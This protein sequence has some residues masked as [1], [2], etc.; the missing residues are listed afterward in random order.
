MRSELK[1]I[2]DALVRYQNTGI[3]NNV[4]VVG[5]RGC[6]KTLSMRYLQKLFADQGLT[7]LYS[8]CRLQNTSY[9]LLAEFLGVRARGVSFA[10]LAER[11][12]RKYTDK[13]VVV[14]DEVD[15]LSEKDRNKDLLYFL[16]RAPEN[17]MVVCLSNNPRW[18][19]V[20]D[21]S[22]QST[23]Q[24]EL[25]Y[26]R[27]YTPDELTAILRERA[28][29]G[30]GKTK[31]ESLANIAALAA[32]YADSDVRVALKTLYYSALE[33]DTPLDTIF[34]RARLDIVVEVV[35]NLN[36]KNLMILKAA[37]PGDRQVKDV[38]ESYRRLCREH[39]DE[40]FSY[41]Y[42]YS[43]L[44]YLQSLGLILLISTKVRRTYTK[45]I[46][47]TFP[48]DVLNTVWQYRFA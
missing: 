21:E 40:P 16:S 37:T 5:P 47:L 23:L 4:L 27:P 10:E 7:V 3:G 48:T 14:L 12:S 46:Q 28:A 32:K 31:D 13:T 1:P 24:P 41:V 43:A 29:A 22:I 15:L 26:F 6:G 30:L 20:L 38:Y 36:D 34:H 39:G 8:N 2:I 11:F 17:Y 25:I 45:L 18:S 33:S 35:R 42:Y 9:K 44:S 19:S